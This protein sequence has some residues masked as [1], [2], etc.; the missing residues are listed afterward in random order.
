MTRI[1]KTSGFLGLAA[2]MLVGLYQATLVAGGSA[3]PGW[4]VGGHAHLG[5]LSILAI[6]VGFTVD[7]LGLTGRLRQAVSGLFVVGQWGVPL[8]VWVAVLVEFPPLHA[9]TF[10]W[11]SALIVSM[12]L[13]AWQ[14]ATTDA[15]LDVTGTA[16]PADD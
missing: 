1:L 3:A 14:A 2:M 6:V 8:T 10:V 16:T 13:M 12:L 11:G 7:V 4:M 5:V 15:T 9:T